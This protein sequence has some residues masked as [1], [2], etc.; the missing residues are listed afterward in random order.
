MSSNLV[1]ARGQKA[2]REK[3]GDAETNPVSQV[4]DVKKA[5]GLYKA[6]QRRPLMN[7]TQIH[8]MYFKDENQ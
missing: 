1:R 7:Y 2:S 4:P 3:K 5:A 6:S 8:M